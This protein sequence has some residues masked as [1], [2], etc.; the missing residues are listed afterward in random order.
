MIIPF[1]ASALHSITANTV[2]TVYLLAT[3]VAFAIIA[4]CNPTFELA[5]LDAWMLGWSF[6]N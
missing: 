4:H 3:M 2:A 5:V 6:K 1:T